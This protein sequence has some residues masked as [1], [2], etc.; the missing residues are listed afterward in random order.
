MVVQ[1]PK[2]DVQVDGTEYY[3]GRLSSVEGSLSA[4]RPP[5]VLCVDGGGGGEQAKRGSSRP[6]AAASLHDDGRSAIPTAQLTVSP[7]R[8]CVN[9]LHEQHQIY[10]DGGYV[11]PT[12]SHSHSTRSPF[13][14]PDGRMEPSAG[15]SV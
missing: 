1:L 9:A 4:L 10:L 3:N 2:R 5:R 15:A 13:S 7:V 14:E 11:H 12:S 6:H 8:A